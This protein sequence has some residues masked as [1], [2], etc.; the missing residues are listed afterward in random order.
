M[1]DP[2]DWQIELDLDGK[3]VDCRLLLK[4]LKE[5]PRKSGSRSWPKRRG[6]RI[7]RPGR[8]DAKSEVTVKKIKARLRLKCSEKTISRALW[9]HGVHMQPLYEKP[10]LTA[11]DVKD[12]RAFQKAHGKLTAKQW[13]RFPHAIIDN[14]VLPGIC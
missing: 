2:V 1:S 7:G 3:H 8:P 9:S 14:K 12:R 6:R 13:Q 4:G 10:T 11:A 5:N